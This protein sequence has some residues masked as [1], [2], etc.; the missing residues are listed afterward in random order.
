MMD[1]KGAAERE[2]KADTSILM[3]EVVAVE[4]NVAVRPKQDMLSFIIIPTVYKSIHFPPR[5]LS[6]IGMRLHRMG[7]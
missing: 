2:E 1:D 7:V 3:V 5:F 4:R 6:C